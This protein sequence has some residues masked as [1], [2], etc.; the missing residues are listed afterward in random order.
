MKLD[1]T[2]KILKTFAK[3]VV[4]LAKKNAKKHKASGQLI[5][6]IGYDYKTMPNSF[7]L[8]FFMNGYGQFVDAGVDGKETKYGKRKYGL[9]TYSFKSKMPPPKKLDKWVVRKGIAPRDAKGRF[10]NRQSLTFAIARSI[11]K[12]G[13]KPSYFFSGAFE[14]AYK[15]MPQEFIDKYE[16]DIDNF[17]K[18]TLKS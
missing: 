15:K 14:Q 12:K 18:F 4:T 17:L 3:N 5:R 8:E 13:F 7:S 2:I 11:F 16:L 6:S 10:Q 9:E 1:E